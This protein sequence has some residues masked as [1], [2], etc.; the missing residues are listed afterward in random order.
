VVVLIVASQFILP[1]AFN[2]HMMDMGTM[3]N[4]GMMMGGPDTMS[5]LFLDFRTSFKV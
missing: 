4:G 3:M 5:Q 2:R 1:T